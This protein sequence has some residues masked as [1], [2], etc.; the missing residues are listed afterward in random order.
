VSG[1]SHKDRLAGRKGRRLAAFQAATTTTSPLPPRRP[2]WSPE[3]YRQTLPEPVRSLSLVPRA[4]APDPPSLHC[5]GSIRGRRSGSPAA[6]GRPMNR[7]PPLPLSS[8]MSGNFDFPPASSTSNPNSDP[9]NDATR[10]GHRARA[11]TQE[12]LGRIRARL[13]SIR[14]FGSEV[15]STLDDNDPFHSNP[16]TTT[17]T[18]EQLERLRTTNRIVRTEFRD[19]LDRVHNRVES[20]L[21]PRSYVSSSN[22]SMP[23]FG[24]RRRPSSSSS[25][26]PPG[27]PRNNPSNHNGSS[28]PPPP[29]TDPP[30]SDVRRRP[31][32]TPSERYPALRRARQ[33]RERDSTTMGNVSEYEQ[34]R[35]SS[36]EELEEA[37]QRL[38]QISENLS[39][40]MDPPP[41]DF[42][43]FGRPSSST[44]R[45]FTQGMDT[46]ASTRR[47][48][49][50]RKLDSDGPSPS[51]QG[52]KYGHYGQ[53]VPGNLKMQI[54][55]CD[56]GEY[57]NKD[58]FWGAKNLLRD[59]DD[60]YCSEKNTCN[61]ILQH[62]GQTTFSISQVVIK[63]PRY[64]FTCP[65]VTP[66]PQG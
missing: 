16:T 22:A 43:M 55:S 8:I 6:V 25:L 26:R 58:G 54:V 18:S 3:P 19:R 57:T 27:N 52:H 59:D 11:I 29:A 50:R 14:S 37:G 30:T 46:E 42:G 38:A 49:K 56:G 35:N 32:A 13:Q 7:R 47:R 31:R 53:V 24:R 15:L 66:N 4:L 34:Q 63:T 10:L 44:A 20:L 65:C 39:Q 45:D 48:H 21:D 61:L 33:L 2:C 12:Q 62:Q 28:S 60:V 36:L 51:L 64:E 5:H 23:P 41:M 9:P 1:I 40:L 17:T